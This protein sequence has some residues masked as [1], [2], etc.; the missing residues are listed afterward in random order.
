MNVQN[1]LTEKINAL[2]TKILS[3]LNSDS[4]AED[5]IRKIILLVQ[6]DLDFESVGV[7]LKEGSD[8][9]YFFTK[10][11]DQDFIEKEMYLCARDE[12]NK[13]IL[14]TQGNPCLECMCGNII[15]GRTNPS[16]P[17]FSEG[18]SFWSNST[19]ELLAK[20]TDKDRQAR[21]RNCCNGEGYESVGLFPVK[22]QGHIYGLLQLN[23]R[24]KNRYQKDL[25]PYFEHIALLLGILF[26]A[27]QTSE[28]FQDKMEDTDRLITLRLL[29]LEKISNEIKNKIEHSKLNIQDIDIVKKLDDLIDEFKVLRGISAICVGCK[30]VKNEQGYWER[31]EDFISER[32]SLQFSH[33][34]CKECY[35]KEIKEIKRDGAPL[36]IKPLE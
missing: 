35:E 10:G 24:R 14:D 16:F 2:S 12:Q 28:K 8:Y 18:G 25:I 3:L 27:K 29:M 36:A 26:L 9:P 22:A 11:F 6:A 32:S 34:Y 1:D 31:V 17:F 5:L 33:T 4:K 13:L 20:T 15:E 21:T 23:D 7:R 30:K 19:T